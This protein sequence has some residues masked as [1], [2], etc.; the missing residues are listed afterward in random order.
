MDWLRE[1]L[2][3]LLT[4]T[5][6]KSVTESLLVVFFDTPMVYRYHKGRVYDKPLT[7]ALD[8]QLIA[9]FEQQQ[10][11]RILHAETMR[12]PYSNTPFLHQY[13]HVYALPQGLLLLQQA[14]Y[15]EAFAAMDLL[16]TAIS[17]LLSQEQLQRQTQTYR[18]WLTAAGMNR[19]QGALEHQGE[20]FTPY[21]AP[22]FVPNAQGFLP[23]SALMLSL[24]EPYSV[25]EVQPSVAPMR[26]FEVHPTWVHH[27]GLY[28]MHL[29]TIDKRVINRYV[30]EILKRYA[31]PFENVKLSVARSTDPL[32]L[33]EVLASMRERPW[34]YYQPSVTTVLDDVTVAMATTKRYKLR[35]HVN[36]W[37]A[38]L[39]VPPTMT[40]ACE[41]AWLTTL[42]KTPPPRTR[43]VQMSEDLAN[44]PDTVAHF[45]HHKMGALWTRTCVVANHISGALATYLQEKNAIIGSRDWNTLMTSSID[46]FLYDHVANQDDETMLD[47]LYYRQM[48]D[49][50]TVIFPIRNQQDALW[51]INH[52]VGLFYKEDANE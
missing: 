2:A 33:E 6:Q 51:L 1:G 35:N 36:Q 12:S 49:G 22:V 34:L 19:T 45:N 21:P 14:N 44:H 39:F 4:Q 46:V 31:S 52:N 32:P 23:Y 41:L 30:N 20:Y 50:L 28:Y 13:L 18:Q 10:H 26:L 3:K 40:I 16:L 25:L 7:N 38:D 27:R 43:Y 37:V 29:P 9:C 47:Y 24:R 5:P 8:P 17:L 15:E 48:T 11:A 42:L